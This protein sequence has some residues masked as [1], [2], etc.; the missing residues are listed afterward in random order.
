[1]NFCVMAL[2]QCW[3]KGLK[4]ICFISELI[5]SVNTAYKL[6]R[7]HCNKENGIKTIYFSR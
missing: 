6:L 2:T 7:H 3:T 1:M 4:L 5:K